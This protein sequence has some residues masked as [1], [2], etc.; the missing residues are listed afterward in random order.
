MDKLYIRLHSFYEFLG[1]KKHFI[2]IIFLK[3]INFQ[4]PRGSYFLLFLP[5]K[6]KALSYTISQLNISN[7]LQWVHWAL[8][9]FNWR[10]AQVTTSCSKRR[11][12]TEIG[13]ATIQVNEGTSRH[14]LE[15]KLTAGT[16]LPRYWLVAHPSILNLM[17]ENPK[18][19]SENLQEFLTV[20]N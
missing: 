14:L 4:F 20:L 17:K 11:P 19:Q 2:L 1:A 7:F 9:L 18:I 6:I 15:I 3:Q 5:L 16:S 12:C 8:P 13:T 10:A